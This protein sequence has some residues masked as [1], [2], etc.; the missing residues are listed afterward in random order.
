MDAVFDDYS[1]RHAHMA[2]KTFYID[3]YDIVLKRV[4]GE[5]DWSKPTSDESRIQSQGP[6]P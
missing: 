1:P 6:I 5:V 4:R 2:P 3:P